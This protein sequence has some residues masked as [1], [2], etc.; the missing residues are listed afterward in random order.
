[1]KLAGA[2]VM[3]TSFSPDEV[4]EFWTIA[5]AIPLVAYVPR[6]PV[7][8]FVHLLKH[9]SLVV[10]R[11][12]Q[13]V[14]IAKS[15]VVFPITLVSYRSWRLVPTPG[16][17]LISGIPNDASSAAGPTPLS[18]KSWGVLKAP[19]DKMTSRVALT[20]PGVPELP[21]LALGSAR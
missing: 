15:L 13:S 6:S 19:A 11:N 10:R 9:G 21:V 5:I 14:V 8:L 1:M 2:P 20:L 17:S 16:R 18:F 4:D 7:G 3:K 12:V